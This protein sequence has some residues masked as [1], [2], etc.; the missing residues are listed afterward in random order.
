M[1]AISAAQTTPVTPP[2]APVGAPRTGGVQ[3]AI[4]S[5]IRSTGAGYQAAARQTA[6]EADKAAI[7][8][9]EAVTTATGL[10]KEKTA[11]IKGVNRATG[12]LHTIGGFGML[13]LTANVS[14]TLRAPGDTAVDLTNRVADLID[15]RDTAKGWSIGWG[16]RSEQQP[17]GSAPV[18]SSALG[19]ALAGAGMK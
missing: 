14:G 17:V 6:V 12:L 19:A 8:P 16:V 9:F 18:A 15:G 7:H 5:L 11:N 10:L 2:T 1:T 13:I 3:G 4:G